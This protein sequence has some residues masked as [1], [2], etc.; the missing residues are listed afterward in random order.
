[1]TMFGITLLWCS[2]G[3]SYPPSASSSPSTC[4]STYST[5]ST[6]ACSPS[7][8]VDQVD[9]ARLLDGEREHQVLDPH[10]RHIRRAWRF[11]G[12]WAFLKLW[13]SKISGCVFWAAQMGIVE[14]NICQEGQIELG[15]LGEHFFLY[16]FPGRPWWTWSSR[17]ICRRSHWLNT[18]TR[19][20]PRIYAHMTSDGK[21]KRSRNKTSNQKYS[22]RKINRSRCAKFVNC[23]KMT[24]HPPTFLDIG[25]GVGVCGVGGKKCSKC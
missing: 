18:G 23:E 7:S 20:C 8:G 2:P 4:S 3:W 17:L 14:I 11:G 13:R 1:M 21:K 12:R 9:P 24:F 10:V 22:L 25:P 6:S 15:D 16:L 19:K 5:S